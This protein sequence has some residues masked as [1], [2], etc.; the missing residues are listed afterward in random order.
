MGFFKKNL[1]LYIE[2]GIL[3][4]SIIIA[5][6][7]IIYVI[8]Y[9][10][11][12]FICLCYKQSFNAEFLKSIT[13]A[14]VIFT[15]S[16]TIITFINN[17]KYQRLKYAIELTDAFES[18]EIRA[19]RNITRKIRK[20]F[21]KGEISAQQ[22]YEYIEEVNQ[23][24][25]IPK[26]IKAFIKK[27]NI[28]ENEF[29]DLN[30]NLIFLFNYWERVYASIEH[31]AVDKDYIIEQL[32][33]VFIGHYE[34]FNVWLKK[35]I[36]IGAP[37]Q[38]EHLKK[39]YKQLKPQKAENVIISLTSYPDRMNIVSNTIESL[40]NQTVEPEKIILWLAATQFKN[41]E[42]DLPKGLLD[43]RSNIFEIKWCEDLRSYKKLIPALNEYSD[44]II[45]TCDDDVIYKSNCIELLL[46]A[47][48]KQQDVIWCHRGHYITFD[49]NKKVKPYEKWIQRISNC[50]PSY[51]ILQ[52]GI[53]AVL[54][55][56][57]CFYKDISKNEIFNQIAKDT[58]DI[59][60]W[61]MAVLNNTK[62]GVVKDNIYKTNPII[63]NDPNTLWKKN[64]NGG[65]DKNFSQIINK[66][67]QILNKLSK[68]TPYFYRAKDKNHNII[69]ILG[70]KIKTRIS[71]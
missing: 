66:Y 30:N 21:S 20:A 29:K 47:Y 33:N 23:N 43:L 50:N 31:N 16:S 18:P 63:K 64:K 19:V 56:P 5:F 6:I 69:N 57:N 41:K 65:N 35:Y 46:K 62:I 9:I 24:N 60:F 45:I 1:K 11:N 17:I 25:M 36:K 55:P 37:E 4:I 22:L 34:R 28:G 70:I 10:A 68:K 49:K 2:N 71:K 15:I 26:D 13:Y 27:N 51:N 59:W 38:Y 58:D 61:A 14:G 67:P 53:G 42:D 32:G 54:Y 48:Q 39:L 52:T 3:Y 8:F 7:A 40:L 12:M 44:K